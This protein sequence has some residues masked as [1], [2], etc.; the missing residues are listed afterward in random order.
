MN[1]KLQA[2]ILINE[3]LLSGTKYI[4]DEKYIPFV[5]RSPIRYIVG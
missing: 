2:A 5:H 1:C 4:D 3:F